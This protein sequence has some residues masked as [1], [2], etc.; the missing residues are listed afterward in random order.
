MAGRL[1]PR[2]CEGDD[3]GG[4]GRGRR[5]AKAAVVE[6]LLH[7]RGRY[8]VVN[9]AADVRMDGEFEVTVAGA[10]QAYVREREGVGVGVEESE[11]QVRLV[12]RLDYATSGVVLL[13]LSRAA[14]AAAARQLERR[15]VRK[16]YVALVHG[17]VT[18]ET[19]C[20][21]AR[22]ADRADRDEF[23][24]AVAARGREAHTHATVL[25]HG[26]WRGARVSKLLLRARSGRRHQLRVHCALAGHPIVGDATYCAP[27]LLARLAPP[28]PRMMLHAVALQLRLPHPQRALPSRRRLRDAR[29]AHEIAP[30]PLHRLRA[31]DPFVH[32]RMP[33]LRLSA[34]HPA[35]MR[36]CASCPPRV[37]SCS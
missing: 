27:P 19:F 17:V 10:A 36:R 8:L 25:A 9:K 26:W 31:P 21:R 15:L 23:R 33:R 34:P 30:W 7:Q 28:P 5:G 11:G 13:A 20:V 37:H 29:L 18:R 4:G 32:E 6:V 16:S 35:R 14:A 24:V 2:R 12:Q 22:V 1:R 3:D